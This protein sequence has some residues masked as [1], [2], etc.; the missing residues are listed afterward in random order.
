MTSDFTDDVVNEKYKKDVS[1][2]M[3][4]LPAYVLRQI[5][6][7]VTLAAAGAVKGL[8]KALVYVPQAPP[9]YMVC[10]LD[11]FPSGKD[12]STWD[13]RYFNTFEAALREFRESP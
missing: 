3:S 4:A 2:N 5:G 7:P 12:F 11:P 9:K 8:P 6:R 10:Y 1:R 13:R